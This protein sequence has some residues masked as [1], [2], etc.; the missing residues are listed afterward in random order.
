M[1]QVQRKA[2]I[3]RNIRRT[4]NQLGTATVFLTPRNQGIAAFKRL[5]PI[6]KV[7]MFYLCLLT[8]IMVVWMAIIHDIIC[9]VFF[10]CSVYFS[11]FSKLSLELNH[12]NDNCCFCW[13]FFHIANVFFWWF[14]LFLL[15]NIWYGDTWLL[16]N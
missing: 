16:H 14:L 6:Q 5:K 7:L 3:T 12:G 8:F 11:V 13:T 1:K 2:K 10:T 15:W 4:D 9:I